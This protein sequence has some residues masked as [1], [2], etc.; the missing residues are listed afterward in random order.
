MESLDFW[1]RASLK[2]V[3]SHV[4]LDFEALWFREEHIR[5]SWSPLSEPCIGLKKMGKPVGIIDV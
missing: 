4:A 5:S 2:G 1:S 3:I